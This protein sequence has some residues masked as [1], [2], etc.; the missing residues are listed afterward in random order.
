MK[1]GFTTS[2]N[3]DKEAIWTSIKHF[4][5]TFIRYDDYLVG[6]RYL[7]GNISKESNIF[8]CTVN[9]RNWMSLNK[10]GPE[11]A[12]LTVQRQTIH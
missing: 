11:F 3:K 7:V 5:S 12:N 8:D 6:Y 1:N 2:N 9:L 10:K 4:G